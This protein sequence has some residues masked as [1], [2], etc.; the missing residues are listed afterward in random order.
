MQMSHQVEISEEDRQ[1]I[2][3]SLALCSLLHP[4][5]HYATGEIAEKYGGRQMF[6]E[7]RACNQDRVSS[8]HA[9]RSE[10]PT[11]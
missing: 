1:M 4:G 8:L 9:D 11:G 6:E 2:L 5:F 10:P 3:L 7:F